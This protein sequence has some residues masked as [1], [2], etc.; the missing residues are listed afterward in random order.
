MALNDVTEKSTK[1]A[2][3]NEIDLDKDFVIDN[4]LK[5]D[6]NVSDTSFKNGKESSKKKPVD[7]DNI[8]E[9][10]NNNVKEATNIFQ[11][12]LI[13]KQQ[14]EE[15][16]RKFNI[17]KSSFE[18]NKELEYEK[19]KEYKKTAYEKLKQKKLVIEKSI[20]ELKQ[21]QEKLNS[22]KISFQEKRKQDL[23]KFKEEK[24][25]SIN[26]MKEKKLQLEELEQELRLEREKLNEEKEQLK[27][28]R[29]Q[30]ESERSELASNLVKFNELVGEF[31]VG[32]EKF[33]DE[34]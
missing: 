29:I 11:K 13:L 33:S 6:S 19:I 21:Q 4:S 20:D 32:I 16:I 28:D 25:K 12:N 22:D 7:I 3:D 31:T 17:E 30:C 18:K 34:N 26:F 10:A 24:Q 1:V 9:K 8:F 23:E 15:K 5:K 27:L 2:N 14:L